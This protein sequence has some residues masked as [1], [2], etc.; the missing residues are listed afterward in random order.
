[1][2]CPI[3]LFSHATASSGKGVN[4]LASPTADLG[5]LLACLHGL[6]ASGEMNFVTLIKT[7]QLALKH[8][9]NR[10]GAQR[11]VVF[12]GSPVVEEERE[13]ARLG[14]VLKKSSVRSESRYSNRDAAE[15]RRMLPTQTF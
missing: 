13:L 11:I 9:K 8:R 6:K 12:V 7:A 4:I 14:A 2:P 5:K 15:L 3:G 10:N 1:M